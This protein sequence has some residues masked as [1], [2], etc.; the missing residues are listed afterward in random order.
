LQA[1]SPSGDDGL[2]VDA[3]L[4][5]QVDPCKFT[6]EEAEMAGTLTSAQMSRATS[7]RLLQVVSNPKFRGKR[8][9]RVRSRAFL[10]AVVKEYG[11]GGVKEAD[12][13]EPLDGNQKMVLYYRDLHSCVVSL[14]QNPR[15]VDRQYTQFRYQRDEGGFRVYGAFNTGE[16]YEFAQVKANALSPNGEKVSPVPVFLSSD[17]TAARKKLPLYPIYCGCPFPHQFRVCST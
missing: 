17:V 16:W 5:E 3:R 14:L 4:I 12:F 8:V 13:T 11:S 2:G 15:F 10:E 6:R 1:R 7:D 9:R